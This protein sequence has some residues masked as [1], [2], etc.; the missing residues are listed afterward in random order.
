MNRVVLVKPSPYGNVYE[1][2]V[3]MVESQ[4]SSRKA[5]DATT[6]QPQSQEQRP[7]TRM[8]DLTLD[9]FQ[10]ITEKYVLFC[11]PMLVKSCYSPHSLAL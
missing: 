8:G 4:Q 5:D 3:F 1:E 7:Q 10:Q 6:V 2:A 11:T 9:E